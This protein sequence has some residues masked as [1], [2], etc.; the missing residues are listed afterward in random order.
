MR[1]DIMP[2]VSATDPNNPDPNPNPESNPSAPITTDIERLLQTTIGESERM[3]REA[4]QRSRD[5]EDELTRLRNQN[6]NPNPSPPSN[7]PTDAQEFWANPVQNISTLIQRQVSPLFEASAQTKR[8]KDYARLKAEYQRYPQFNLIEAAV[9]N[10]MQNQEVTHANMQA[11]IQ[12]AV[13]FLVLNNPAALVP[14]PVVDP[15]NPPNPNP[16]NQR[17]PEPQAHLRPS[18]T[19]TPSQNNKPTRRPLTEL[20]KRVM[21]EMNIKTE[22]KYWELLESQSQVETWKEPK[23]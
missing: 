5:L 22:E 7:V 10:F 3:R 8:D 21:K 20:E 11:A 18:N 4:E 12:R 16:Q 19:P 13:G 6:N 23:K 1:K 15:N 14:K 9:D 2:E 17:T